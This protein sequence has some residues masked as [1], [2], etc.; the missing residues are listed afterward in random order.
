MKSYNNQFLTVDSERV[1]LTNSVDPVIHALD[2]YFKGAG[3]TARVTRALT[4]PKGQLRVIKQY[5]RAKGLDRRFNSLIECEDV[6]ELTDDGRYFI[7]QEGWSRLLNLGVI[8]NPPVR[9]MVLMDY[10]GPHGNGANRKGTYINSTPHTQGNCFDIGGRGGLDHTIKDELV[11]IQKA[12][13]DKLPGMVS[14]LAEHNNNCIHVNCRA[15]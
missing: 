12:Y 1:V 5:I 6:N 4:D 15:L 8:I 13:K 11:I 2:S 14:Y 7:W 9:A 3:L 10:F